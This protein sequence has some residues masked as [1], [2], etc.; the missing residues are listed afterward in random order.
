M[1]IL[2]IEPMNLIQSICC[3][4][5]SRCTSAAAEPKNADQ[6]GYVQ[7]RDAATAPPPPRPATPETQ[8]SLLGR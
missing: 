7:T 2:R 3:F 6:D 5:S 1:H 4:F 8:D